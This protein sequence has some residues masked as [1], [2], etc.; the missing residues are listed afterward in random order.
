MEQGTAHPDQSGGEPGWH[1]AVGHQR[2]HEREADLA[3]VDEVRPVRGRLASWIEL[4]SN[5][6]YVPKPLNYYS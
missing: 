5:D 3:A 2:A 4:G 6:Y 1:R